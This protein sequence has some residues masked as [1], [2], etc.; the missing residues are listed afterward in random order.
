MQLTGSRRHP[1]L[2]AAGLMQPSPACRSPAAAAFHSGRLPA[3]GPLGRKG[4]RRA[5]GCVASGSGGD[6]GVGFGAPPKPDTLA[7]AAEAESFFRWARSAGVDFQ[8]LR[9]GTFDGA[10]S[11]FDADQAERPASVF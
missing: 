3:L 8:K 9:I 1:P 5:G 2:A 10:K 11:S 4:L 6:G 7:E